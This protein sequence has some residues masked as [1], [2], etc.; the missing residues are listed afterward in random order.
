MRKVWSCC[1][2]CQQMVLSDGVKHKCPTII[3]EIMEERLD[4]ETGYLLSSFNEDL[5]DFWTDPHTKFYKYLAENG[6]I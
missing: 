4:E 5:K 6:D 3:A 2:C 1:P